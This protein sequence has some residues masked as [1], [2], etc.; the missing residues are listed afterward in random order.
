MIAIIF[1]PTAR[2]EKA[3]RFQ[4][5]LGELGEKCKLKPTTAPGA[6]RI[7]AAEAVREKYETIVAAGGDGTVNEVL[8]GIGDADG[9]NKC[10]LAILPL[11]TINV[12]A[13]ELGLPA[14][15]ADN[16]K[17]ILRGHEMK[18]DLPVAE[19]FEKNKSVR[20]YF[21]QLAG[22]GL[23]SR[24]IE[25]VN[26]E[27]KKKV[28]PLAY[29]HA[30]FQALKNKSAPI[31]VKI[32][33]QT[34]RGELVL[35]GNGKFYGGKLT[36]FPNANLSDGL[37]HLCIFPKVNIEAMFRCGWGLLTNQMLKESGAKFLSAE[38]FTLSSESSA[39]VQLDGDNVGHLPAT[40]SVQ[41]EKLRVIVR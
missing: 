7:L 23:D 30:G 27:L 11:G 2:G 4:A 38:K 26:W 17:I 18:V 37:L 8:N 13:K 28:G 24:A 12:F 21:A 33:N 20:R 35:I 5:N 19:F 31:E 41:R 32:G 40:F 1:N 25:L 14:R 3:K 9:F 39:P 6:A 29:I 10:R 36:F 34:E 16:F 22:A 15:V